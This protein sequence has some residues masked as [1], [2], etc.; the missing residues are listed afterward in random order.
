MADTEVVLYLTQCILTAPTSTE[1]PTKRNVIKGALESLGLNI[2]R[3][4]LPQSDIRRIVGKTKK[5]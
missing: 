4:L 1:T 5:N 2:K 3:K